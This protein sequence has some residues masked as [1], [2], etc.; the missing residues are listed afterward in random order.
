[1]NMNMNEDRLQAHRTFF[2]NLLTASIGQPKGRLTEA[3]AST[4]REHFVGPGPWSI[5]TA[6]GYIETP[7]DDPA[8]LYQN[9]TVALIKEKRINNGEPILHAAS[10][11]ALNVKEGETIVHIGAGAGYYT[12][13]LARLTGP[14]GTVVAYEIEP[15]LARRAT[16][17]L[18][19]L[20]NATVHDQSGAER[21]LPGCDVIYVNAGATAPL[22]T[23]LDALRPGG[24]L[25]FP[26][27][28]AEGP[29]GIPGAGAMLLVTHVSPS[30]FD[31][32]FL[33]PVMF[34]SCVGA[35]DDETAKKLSEAF[36]RGDM[37]NVQSLRRNT[38]PD[39]SCWC[40]GN[41]WW[42]STAKQLVENGH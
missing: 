18:A 23:W 8:F 6:S 42:L 31:A 14:T 39:E 19:D 17:N 10:L 9:V 29:G 26:L 7:S 37:K 3:F 27:T 21:P 25:L 11:A 12:A 22:D 36:K 34:I 15:E 16:T 20:P 32:R 30:H 5:F 24:R 1:M 33:Y 13:L 28:P 4:P 35:R 40:S 41:G 2:A 38:P